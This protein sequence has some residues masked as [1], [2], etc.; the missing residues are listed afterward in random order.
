MA[1]VP[2]DSD[3]L[4]AVLLYSIK[5]VLLYLQVPVMLV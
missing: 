3:I 4:Y 1:A 2:L 5:T